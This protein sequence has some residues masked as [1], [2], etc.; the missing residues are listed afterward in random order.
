VLT[1]HWQA[2]PPRFKL[3]LRV[4]SGSRSEGI[5]SC[6]NLP[7][8][9]AKREESSLYSLFRPTN[10][11]VS[12]EHQKT[13]DS[14]DD[15]RLPITSLVAQLC[16]RSVL[17]AAFI[18]PS[19]F[20][21]SS[22]IYHRWLFVGWLGCGLH[23]WFFLIAFCCFLRRWPSFEMTFLVRE[24]QVIIVVIGHCSS[25]V[26]VPYTTCLSLPPTR[27]ISLVCGNGC[28]H[29]F[30]CL[31]FTFQL[32]KMVDAAPGTWRTRW[33]ARENRDEQHWTRQSVLRSLD[34]RVQQSTSIDFFSHLP[35]LVLFCFL[36]YELIFD[37]PWSTWCPYFFRYMFVENGSELFTVYRLGL[38]LQ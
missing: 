31:P 18:L 25:L 10:E 26:L 3:N 14:R 37:C 23:I 9:T 13:T 8:D 32:N 36:G 20:C 5:R 30:E 16:W 27:F 7:S 21:L 35:S 19:V 34:S 2:P 11:K 38:V 4:L 24:D 28:L 1:C 29:D 17:R 33:G 22:N 15:A 6:T 12:T